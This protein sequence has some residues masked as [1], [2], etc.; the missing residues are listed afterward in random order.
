MSIPLSPTLQDILVD[1]LGYNLTRSF[2]AS[3]APLQILDKSSQANVFEV[4]GEASELF[5]EPEKIPDIKTNLA[6]V[7]I[8]SMYTSNLTI[9]L[10]VSFL[11]DFLKKSIFGKAELTALFKNVKTFTT[12]FSK[13][14]SDVVY[15]LETARFLR[16]SSQEGINESALVT[17]RILDN[18]SPSNPSYIITET[19][20][21]CEIS[22]TAKDDKQLTITPKIEILKAL[23]LDGKIDYQVTNDGSV[24]LAYTI[25]MVFAFKACPIWVKNQTILVAPPKLLPSASSVPV[26]DIPLEYAFA[27]PSSLDNPEILTP[28]LLSR[29]RMPIRLESSR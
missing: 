7:D 10:T 16:K 28:V 11:E 9:S 24:K 22:I 6:V 8:S 4:L 25:P 14:S 17:S 15:P 12:N 23:N 3:L 18:V 1:Y 19:L 13:C 2:S 5:Y 20:K 27:L 29:D 21:A 26:A